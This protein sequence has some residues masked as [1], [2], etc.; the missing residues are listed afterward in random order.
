MQRSLRGTLIGATAFAAAVG[1]AA[2]TAA[3]GV[4]AAS[5]EAFGAGASYS[6]PEPTGAHGVGTEVLH[7]VDG[8]R[9]DPW[10][11]DQDRQLMVT[12]WFP[13]EDQGETAPYMT[14][15]ESAAFAEQLP[16]DVPADYFATVET[17]AVADAEPVDGKLPLVMLS[18][19]WSFP[20]ATLTS[21][22]E[23]LASRGYAVAAVGH[24][25]EA[26]MEL[27]DGTINP[28][29]AC[30]TRPTGFDVTTGRAADL[31][32]VLD[33]LTQ[34]GSEWRRHLDRDRIAVGGHSMGGSAAHTVMQTDERFEAG[35]N[36]DG[37]LHDAADAPI[38]EPFLLV[39][40]AVNGMPGEA[41][42]W[43][44]AW[45]QM[46]DWK[47]WI[48]VEQTTHSTFT[49]LALFADDLGIPIQ[50]MEGTRAVKL[51][52]AYVAAFVNRELRGEDEPILDGPSTEWPEVQF[53]NP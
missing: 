19:G 42:G 31:A 13:T 53:H 44:S 45:E 33:E 20:R 24:N 26:P 16:E 3:A 21:L 51:T 18:P 36:L 9:A 27:P 43:L 1:A 7:F 11:P 2:A 5:A 12:M 22:A 50:E 14:A 48:R 4:T 28:C 6:L 39:G 47:R 34:R 8:D 37:A 30:P 23:E 25:Y 35:F 41:A 52:R 38:D 49:D 10:F 29:L 15:G 17:N 32:F 46:D 40:N